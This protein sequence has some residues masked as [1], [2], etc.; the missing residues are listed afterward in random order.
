ML[1]KI[2]IHK[3]E[4]NHE[5]TNRYKHTS[6]LLLEYIMVRLQLQTH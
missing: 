1:E 4:T 5:F 2:W 3:Y 6:L